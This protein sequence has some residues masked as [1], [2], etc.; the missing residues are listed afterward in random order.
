MRPDST[1]P[2]DDLATPLTLEHF[3]IPYKPTFCPGELAELFGVSAQTFYREIADGNL[4]AVRIR[5][6]LRVPL[7]ELKAY[8]ERNQFQG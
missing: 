5:G 7:A 3:A 8:L 4:R 1:A 6:S 2:P